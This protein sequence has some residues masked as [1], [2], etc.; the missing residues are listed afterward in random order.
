MYY[1]IAGMVAM[2]MLGWWARGR[3]DVDK[4]EKLLLDVTND[5]NNELRRRI[6]AEMRCSP[7][8][9]PADPR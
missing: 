4:L 7:E 2:F 3:L 8:P 5:R 9:Q 1:A 6:A